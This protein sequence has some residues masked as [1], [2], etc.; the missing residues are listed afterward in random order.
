MRSGGAVAPG[1]GYA[2]GRFEP[3]R[4]AAGGGTIAGGI[5]GR[6]ESSA[7][8]LAGVVWICGKGRAA[9]IRA[10]G[11]IARAGRNIHSERGVR[12]VLCAVIGDRGTG[13][14]GA[15]GI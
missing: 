12:G 9:G 2:A 5:G 3:G 7:D 4:P 14:E 6:V 11:E 8:G 1:G 13:A 10:A 15:R